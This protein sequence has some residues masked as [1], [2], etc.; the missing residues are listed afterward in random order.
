[1]GV[2]HNRFL[3]DRDLRSAQFFVQNCDVGG[4]Q[5]SAPYRRYP[6][7]R[8][9]RFHAKAEF[10]IIGRARGLPPAHPAPESGPGPDSPRGLSTGG[11]VALRGSRRSR[12]SPVLLSPAT[13]VRCN[14]CNRLIGQK[15]APEG[16]LPRGLWS[17]RLVGRESLSQHQPTSRDAIPMRRDVERGNGDAEF[18]GF[19]ADHHIP[20]PK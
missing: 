5:R 16:L 11:S 7:F 19:H 15:N 12:S 20:L 13:T 10:K 4:T 1:M 3:V 9:S 2:G 18:N 17:G 8:D 6:Q 14:R